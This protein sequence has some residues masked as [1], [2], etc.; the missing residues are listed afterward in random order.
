M[1]QACPFCARVEDE[2]DLMAESESSA[3]FLDGFPVT[4]GHRLV[5]P[6]R[7]VAR[8]DELDSSE[9][10]DLFD[11]VR[12]VSQE[13]AATHGVDGLTIGINSGESAGQ[14]V[15]HA[16]VHVIPRSRGD[17]DDPRGGVRNVIP[18]KADYWSGD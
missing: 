15:P 18:G 16:H 7:H 14:T 1:D 5:V 3:C 4:E 12:Q 10:A 9:W 2:N 6:K 17:V 11:L 8:V 13:L